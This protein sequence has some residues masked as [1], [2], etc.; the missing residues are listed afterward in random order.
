MIKSLDNPADPLFS[1]YLPELSKLLTDSNLIILEKSIFCIQN[2]CNKIEPHIFLSITS[3]E[4]K[5]M[6]KSLI[7]KG[8]GTNKMVIKGQVEEILIFFA[9]RVE[10]EGVIDACVGLLGHKNPKVENL[11]FCY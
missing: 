10:K 9:R 4:W 7:E 11:K 8:Y 6:L 2:I 3:F 5:E 1:E